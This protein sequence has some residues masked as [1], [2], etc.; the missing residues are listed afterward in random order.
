[1]INNPSIG[2]VWL[3]AS[4]ILTILLFSCS[5]PKILVPA[6]SSEEKAVREAQATRDYNKLFAIYGS[7]TKARPLVED[8][9]FTAAPSSAL[10]LRSH[11]YERVLSYLSMVEEGTP[12]HDYIGNVKAEQEVEIINTVSNLTSERTNDYLKQYPQRE[13]LVKQSLNTALLSNLDS[14]SYLELDY[15]SNTIPTVIDKRIKDERG[16]RTDE[17]RSILAN[18]IDDFFKDENNL[19]KGL[20][21]SIEEKAYDYLYAGYQEVANYYSQIGMVPDNPQAA[22]GQYKQ[23]V[24]GCLSSKP[25]NDMI[26]KEVNKFCK[27]VNEARSKYVERLNSNK[28]YYVPM[29]LKVPS[30]SFV[31]RQDTSPFEKIYKARKEEAESRKKSKKVAGIASWFGLGTVAKIGKGIYDLATVSEMASKEVKQRRDYM[32][33]VYGQLNA[34]LKKQLNSA[35]AT[36][37]GSIKNNQAEFKSR[38][39][40]KSNAKTSKK[41]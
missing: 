41:K 9:F 12:L 11:P 23:L 29:N 18:D 21:L 14:L 38:I 13:S 28:K 34:S 33:S 37:D 30:I 24:D 16:Q 2:H 10:D 40:Q 17:V 7:N 8:A 19:V 32:D 15:V 35:M 25:L 26:Q 20:Y 22:A 36:M 6:Y 4:M 1:M 27:E 5:S 31:Y 3:V 39:T